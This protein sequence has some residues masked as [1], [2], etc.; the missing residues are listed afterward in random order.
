ML[1]V[2]LAC[3]LLTVALFGYVFSARP[4][5]EN[6]S[7][8]EAQ[9]QAWEER[10]RAVYENLKDLHFEHLAGKLNDADF[11]RSRGMLEQE[12]ATLTAKLETRP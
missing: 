12:A 9:R 5:A 6:L 10:K 7:R 4:E 1:P 2:A 11:Q 3:G 8:S